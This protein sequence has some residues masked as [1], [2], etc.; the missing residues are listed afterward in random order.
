MV[1]KYQVYEPQLN[2]RSSFRRHF[3]C[4]AHGTLFFSNW[5]FHAS[6]VTALLVQKIQWEKFLKHCVVLL[7]SHVWWNKNGKSYLCCFF[8]FHNTVCDSD[9][10]R[11]PQAWDGTVPRSTTQMRLGNGGKEICKSI[12]DLKSWCL[13]SQ[14]L[15][16]YLFNTSCIFSIYL[17]L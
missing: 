14:N 16:L 8:V 11:F 2:R 4:C 10:Y 12:W 13:L 5:L 3:N 7:P 17:K 15:W 1:L 6:E 9:V